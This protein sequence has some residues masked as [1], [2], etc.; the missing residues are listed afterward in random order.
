MKI[1][2]NKY[3]IAGAIVLTLLIGRSVLLKKPSTEITYI[4]SKGTMVDSIQVSGTYTTAAQTEVF[5]PTNGVITK[6]YVSNNDQ[7][8]KNDLLF[9]I[10]STATN[11]EKA[12]AYATYLS[13][14]SSLNTSKQSKESL[15][16]S[17]WSKQKTVLDA[18]NNLDLMNERLVE[19]L[20]NPSTGSEYTELEINSIRSAATTAI[21]DFE[22]VEDQYK[23]SD[24]AI[25]SAQAAVLSSKLAYDAT[26]SI[27]VRA[28]ADGKVV[29]LLKTIGDG[30]E[31]HTATKTA[32]AVLVIANLE[33]PSITAKISEAY[34]S[35]LEE[36]QKA[37]IVFDAIRDD[38]FTGLV[39]RIDMVGTNNGGV[40]TYNARIIVND[41]VAGVK[42]GMTSTITIET[43]RKED[44]ISI[45]N[46]AI[47]IQ[48]GK[49]YVKEVG[50]NKTNLIEVKLG[51]RGITKTEIVNGLSEDMEI[52]VNLNSN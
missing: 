45:P 10:E 18:Q 8:A 51:V 46:S 2:K 35:Q 15:D 27:T 30:V 28:S 34:I 6:L 42:P 48:D 50:K 33:N 21:K 52:L 43:F 37:K 29:N 16:A 32:P 44:V 7:V 23:K 49:T 40:V 5:S 12:V 36:G 24:T 1:N 17:M 13:K 4:V 22:S 14:L 11:E 26:K 25:A 19:G 47:A 39:E 3:I 20:S 41:I 9:Y 38:V 31:A